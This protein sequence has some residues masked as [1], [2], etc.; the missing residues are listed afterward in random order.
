MPA[1]N[2]PAIQAPRGAIFVS[3]KVGCVRLDLFG[4]VSEGI[5]RDAERVASM[6][7]PVAGSPAFLKTATEA[8]QFMLGLLKAE[9][10]AE[11]LKSLREDFGGAREM[12]APYEIGLPGRAW[13]GEQCLAQAFQWATDRPLQHDRN[14]ADD[15]F[16]SA[17][18]EAFCD[19][20][21]AAEVAA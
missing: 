15:E 4:R 11:C 10:T 13:L 2:L 7:P 17:I 20:F 5:R 9:M 21:F 1:F 19:L 14:A 8:A 16:T 18:W 3:K 6:R 12:F